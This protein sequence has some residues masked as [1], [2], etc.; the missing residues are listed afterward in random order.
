MHLPKSTWVKD[1]ES[2]ILI[3]VRGSCVIRFAPETGRDPKALQSIMDI[4]KSFFTA[5]LVAA[6]LPPDSSAAT[7]GFYAPYFR[8][9]AGTEVAGWERF[10]SGYNVANQ[11][12]MSG[13]NMGSRATLTQ[14]DPVGAVLGSG[15]IYVG[16]GGAG[17]FKLNYSG[18]QP[19]AQISFQIR[20]LGTEIDYSGLRLNYVSLDKPVSLSGTPTTLA[21]SPS[22]GF[23]GNN[24]SLAYTW[25]V[26]DPGVKDFNLTFKATGEHLSLDSMTLDVMPTTVPEP[27]TWALAGLGLAAWTLVTRRR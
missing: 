2:P 4:Q 6:T 13:S 5:V 18:L 22:Q 21:I 7:N 25:N 11:P 19:I 27:G 24:I 26:S 23:P 1:F 3:S 8:G 12:D 20:T 15:N 9:V 10:S 16:V 17:N 14:L